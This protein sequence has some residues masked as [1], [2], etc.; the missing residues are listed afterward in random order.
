MNTLILAFLSLVALVATVILWPFA[1][2]GLLALV[3]SGMKFNRWVSSGLALVLV[4]V[5]RIV[6]GG[7]IIRI[8]DSTPEY[9]YYETLPG[10]VSWALAAILVPGFAQWPAKFLE[11]YRS[12]L[13]KIPECPPKESEAQQAA[14]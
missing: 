6:T 11:G 2:A 5:W 8:G 10:I 13:S 3:L 7:W 12:R 4:V 9:W 1:V 14:P